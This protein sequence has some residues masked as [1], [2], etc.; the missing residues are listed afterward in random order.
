MRQIESMYRVPSSLTNK[1]FVTFS[2]L[3]WAVICPVM[4]PA[5]PFRWNHRRIIIKPKCGTIFHPSI[6]TCLF[7]IEIIRYSFN[8][9]FIYNRNGWTHQK[10]NCC[11]HSIYYQT[12]LYP[13]DNR[14][15]SRRDC[16][17]MCINSLFLGHRDTQLT[18]LTM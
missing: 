15:S 6:P 18:E 13:L 11:F 17:G 9:F 10:N 3:T 5:K 14:F 2:D 7:C 4:N 1:T 8:L 12:G 16:K